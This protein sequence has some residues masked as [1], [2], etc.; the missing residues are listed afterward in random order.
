MTII[1][2]TK[3][4]N[5]GFVRQEKMI[6]HQQANCELLF[7]KVKNKVN[8]RHKVLSFPKINGVPA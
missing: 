3:V 6:I 5:A 2:S 1:Q 8:L 7:R 4:N